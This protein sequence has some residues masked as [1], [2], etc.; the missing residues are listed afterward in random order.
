MLS[1]CVKQAGKTFFSTKNLLGVQFYQFSGA[2]AEVDSNKQGNRRIS[3]I[4]TRSFSGFLISTKNRQGSLS[5]I[6]DIFAKNGINLT[7]IESQLLNKSP[8]G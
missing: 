5:K 6:L 2:A 7:Y 4:L 8:A 3:S 1:K